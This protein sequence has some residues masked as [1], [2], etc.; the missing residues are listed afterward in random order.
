M[1]KV[2]HLSAKKEVEDK[3]KI[4][5]SA[6]TEVTVTKII[7]KPENIRIWIDIDDPT[8]ELLFELEKIKQSGA[9]CDMEL[10]EHV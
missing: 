9:V 8:P 4:P 1:G 3:D 7:S 2:L 10:K 5:L 6:A